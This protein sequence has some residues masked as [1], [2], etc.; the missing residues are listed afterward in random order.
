MEFT[1]MP[2]A[3]QKYLIVSLYNRQ[4]LLFHY[5][6]LHGLTS[7][8]CSPFWGW[9]RINL[10]MHE[11]THP[12]DENEMEALN[13]F[14]LPLLD[15]PKPQNLPPGMIWQKSWKGEPVAYPCAGIL[16]PPKCISLSG[17]LRILTNLKPLNGL[18]P[19]QRR[20]WLLSFKDDGHLNI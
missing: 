2:N 8:W 16:F 19:F 4:N 17:F 9:T 1:L 5:I 13:P 18:L 11:V 15:L 10:K 20:L 3:Y 6:V 14:S 12:R 7:W